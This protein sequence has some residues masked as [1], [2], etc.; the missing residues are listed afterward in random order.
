MAGVPFRLPDV[1]LSLSTTRNRQDLYVYLSLL[2]LGVLQL[3]L[4][5]WSSEFVSDSYYYELAHSIL[6]RAGYGFNFRPE[7]QIP[8]GFPALLALLMLVA[9]HSYALLIRSIPVF[10][11]LGFIASYEVL[12]AEEGRGFAALTCLLLASSPSWFAVKSSQQSPPKLG[13]S[14][15]A[16]APGAVMALPFRFRCFR[17]RT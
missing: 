8:P 11:T 2:A 13:D 4:S 3:A 10:T 5:S 12:K 7:P 1:R 14:P 17:L 6:A 9:G 15:M 16:R